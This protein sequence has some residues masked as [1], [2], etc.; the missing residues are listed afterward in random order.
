MEFGNIFCIKIPLSPRAVWL[1]EESD[2]ALN[3]GP[4][5]R[6]LWEFIPFFFRLLYLR[7]DSYPAV[8]LGSQLPLRSRNHASLLKIMISAM[9]YRTLVMW[10]NDQ[11]PF[12]F[13][14]FLSF[15]LSLTLTNK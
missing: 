3:T 15:I 1:C 14:R 10:T 7:E 11:N 4:I 8:D 12:S 9:L 13:G 2:S 6:F 5:L